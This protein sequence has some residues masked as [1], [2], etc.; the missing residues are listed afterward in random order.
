[1]IG[2]LRN[3]YGGALVCR[4]P[5]EFDDLSD[6]LPIPDHQEVFV[7]HS[8]NVTRDKSTN[9]GETSDYVLSFEILEQ[10]GKENEALAR[11]LFD[12]LA[13]SNEA[14][15]KR[16]MTY[17]HLKTSSETGAENSEAILATGI[18]DVAKGLGTHRGPARRTSV[19]LYIWRLPERKSD[20]LVSYHF[21]FDE[22]G[23]DGDQQLSLF[24]AMVNTLTIRDITLFEPRPE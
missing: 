20:I 8:N 7:H 9:D 1:M 13:Y 14:T 18:M 10:V 21:P 22:T 6:L 17:Q 12:D 19:F 24:K 16:F 15:H 3:L 4:I 11:Y 2:P 5:Q 23:V